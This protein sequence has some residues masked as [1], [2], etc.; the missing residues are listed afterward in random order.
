[1]SARM[2]R[3]TLRVGSCAL[4]VMLL[5]IAPSVRALA[6]AVC[7]NRVFPATLTMDDPGVGDELSLP[8]LQYVPIPSSDGTPSGHQTSYGYEWDKTITPHFGFAVEGG[9]IVQRG[10][11]QNVSGWDNTAVTLKYEL[12]CNE[13]HEFMVSLGV[14]REFAGTGSPQLRNAGVIDDVSS[15][16]PTIYV[17]KGL[18]DLPIG[19]LRPLAI[20]G[21]ASYQI[22]DSPGISPDQWNYAVSLQYSM[23]YL[24]QH[25]KALAVP[26]FF[27]RLVPL[28]EI[29][30]S[31]PTDSPTT[32]T[33]SPGIFYEA[34]TWQ[35]GVEVMFPINAATRQS[36][37]T[38]FIA[39]Y[40]LFLDDILP[41]SL[42]RPLFSND[43]FAMKSNQGE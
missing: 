39:Q 12:P 18:G 14:S 34:D 3:P 30:M 11:G 42:G 38:A 21:E 5:F 1:M 35:L 36:Q 25:V 28:V 37:G 13:D 20:T 27:T 23:P 40:H 24:Q 26:E 16:A 32:G 43:L 2:V 10:A 8:T 9:Y 6:H 33:V 29:A 19:Y 41:H 15:T 17:G 7:G 22:S 4:A 31:S